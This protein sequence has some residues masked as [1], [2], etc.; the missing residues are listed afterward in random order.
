MG[1][2]TRWL[3]AA[4]LAAAWALV[5]V[6]PAAAFDGFG[7]AT[8]D[9]TYDVEIRFDVELPGSAPDRLEL[10]LSTPGSESIVRRPDRPRRVRRDLRLG[11]VGRPRHPQHPGDL[12][13]ARHRWRGRHSLGG[14]QHQVRG[15]PGGPRL[16]AGPAGRDDRA[17]VRRRRGAGAALRR[18]GGARGR[19]GRGAARHRAG[20]TGRRLRLRHP[21]RLLRCAGARRSR[22]DRRRG[23]HRDPHHLHVARRRTAGLPRGGDG[24]RGHPRRL[25]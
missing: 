17:L 7:E 2:L 14:R 24:P 15:R 1:R 16:A 9:S 5:S 13:M 21:R 3:G 18:A 23:L 19:P 25:L 12:P 20:R 4:G 22:V 6:G 10:L 11:H 8:A